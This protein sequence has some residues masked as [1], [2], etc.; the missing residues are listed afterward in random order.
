MNVTFDKQNAVEGIVSVVLEEKDYC[1]KVADELK[2]IGKTHAEPGFR[3]GH[4][5]AGLIQK[6]YGKAVKFDVIN[7]EVSDALYDYIKEQKLHVLGNPMGVDDEQLDPEAA[8]YTFKFRVGLAPEIQS[9]VNKDMH[10]PYYNIEVS[11]EM[12]NR[13]DEALR[14]QF[15]K[16]EPGDTVEEDALVKGTFAELNEDGS[17]KEGGV[18]QENGIVA[19]KY[20]KSEDQRNLFVGKK[21]GEEVRFNP[22]ATCEGNPTEL[23]SMLGIDKD[24]ADS[25]KG[26]FLCT[27]REIIVLRPAELGE[28]Y[29]EQ[30]FGKDKVK[31]EAEYRNALNEMI[32]NRLKADSN[33]RFTIDAKE[34]IL[35]AVG[36]I[37]LPDAFLKAYLKQQNEK[38]T[39]EDIEKEYPALRS[40]LVWQLVRDVIASQ[41][42]IKIE[43]TDLQ[44][45]ARLVTRN[46]FAQFG[47]S[48]VPDEMLENYSKR[49][50][51]DE[52]Q[53]RAL[54]EQ[55]LDMKLFEGIK[56]TVTSEEKNVSVEDFN[57]LFTAAEAEA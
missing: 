28:E 47:M 27:I 31:D 9:P 8:D 33:Y 54:A 55:A 56:N 1:G 52:K 29:Y 21:N 16:Q 11:E 39:E 42:N 37:E 32:A 53:R 4:V 12:T 41:L 15:G 13:Q 30:V 24:Q 7:R 18:T 23:A 50:L 43:E 34:E 57:K 45:V 44:E 2:K 5:P 48:N 51:E 14:K 6:K 17:V 26:D 46:Q 10:V 35:K 25:Y 19:P 36:E 38:A 22:W 40:D 20:F 3:A 49:L